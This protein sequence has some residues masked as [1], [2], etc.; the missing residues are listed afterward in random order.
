MPV[1]VPEF[2]ALTNSQYGLAVRCFLQ[3]QVASSFGS[4]CNNHHDKSAPHGDLCTFQ[5]RDTWN[6]SRTLKSV[7]KTRG[8]HVAAAL[9]GLGTGATLACIAATIGLRYGPAYIGVVGAVGVLGRLASV[10]VEHRNRYPNYAS[11]LFL[12]IASSFAVVFAAYLGS[13]QIAALVF[14]LFAAGNLLYG[15]SL[16]A[17]SEGRISQV[18]AFGMSGQAAAQVLVGVAFALSRPWGLFMSCLLIALQAVSLALWHPKYEPEE[19][20]QPS[21][22]R[23][24]WGLYFLPALLLSIAGY[25]PLA[26]AAT[27][28]ARGFGS[29]WMGLGLACYAVG[30]LVVPV[31][32][33]LR[34]LRTYSPL[35]CGALLACSSLT[36][37]IGTQSLALLAASRLISGVCAFTAQS[38]IIR[39]ASGKNDRVALSLCSL[40]LGV[41]VQFGALW[42][43]PIAAV[44]VYAMGVSSAVASIA[45]GFAI[46]VW[47]RKYKD[48]NLT[49]SH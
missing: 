11:R 25:G 22:T 42:C 37:L 26:L 40:G 18:G 30:A 1:E 3:V 38:A 7:Q 23:A 33:R 16:I 10:L 44:S 20:D 17:S 15:T 41:G 24:A 27:L 32:E 29:E 47:E 13:W 34:P 4:S 9:D 19:T 49:R 14:S 46:H 39:K 28:V 36:W 35:A 48:R 2:P 43:G 6:N 31:I 8:L 5:D 12:A 21:P 45:C